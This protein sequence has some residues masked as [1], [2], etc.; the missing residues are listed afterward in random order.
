MNINDEQFFYE[1][2]VAMVSQKTGLVKYGL[3]LS[4]HPQWQS[5][6]NPKKK[7]LSQSPYVL[8]IVWHPNGNEE[9]VPDN[10]VPTL[11]IYL[12]HKCFSY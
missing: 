10:K 2:E 12:Y 7:K 1:D 9:I 8:K 3:V 6:G 5:H 4:T 11:T